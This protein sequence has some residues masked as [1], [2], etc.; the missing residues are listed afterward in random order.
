MSNPSPFEQM[1][2]EYINRA[3]MDPQGEFDR[4]IVNTNPVQAIEGNITSALNFFDVDLALYQQQLAGLSPAAP[5][6][7][8]SALNNAATAHS[9][10]M[11]AKDSQSHQLPGEAGLGSRISAAGYDH[12]GY[13]AENIFA[14]TQSPAYGHAGFFIDWGNTPTGIQNPAGHRNNIMNENLTEVGIGMVADSSDSTNVGP[15]VVTQDFGDRWDYDAQFVG[16]AY[17][18]TDLDNFYSIGEGAGGINVTLTSPVGGSIATATFSS[19]GFQ[20]EGAPGLNTLTFSGGGI[21]GSVSVD[22]L[23]GSDNVKVDLVNGTRIES[24]ADATLGDGVLDL[25]LLGQSSTE[26][27]GN[28]LGNTLVGSSGD[29][30]MWGKGGGDSLSGGQGN[31]ELFGNVGDDFIEGGAGDDLLHGGKDNDWV[32]GLEHADT[33]KGG[34][35]SDTLEGGADNDLLYGNFDNDSL[36]GESGADY[37]HGG[38]DDDWLDGGS[39]TDTL[40]GGQGEDTLNGGSGAD[41]LTGGGGNDVFDFRSISDSAAGHGNRDV[42]AGGFDSPG[43]GAGD[44]IDVSDIGL[45][46]FLG[47][48]A[49]SGTGWSEL[50]VAAAGTDDAI[51]QGDVDGNSVADFEIIIEDCL[52]NTFGAED[53]VGLF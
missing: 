52:A 27:V 33:L 47:E 17:N 38:K 41:R 12:W 39:G 24:S 48:G 1:M 3:R 21:S 46:V 5:L 13:L 11:I 28:A 44:L 40:I 49:F 15:Y 9:Q 30:R 6:A 7:W 50:R 20:I 25:T 53:F 18:D 2:L 32:D 34:L 45:F 43:A 51:V 35:G 23:F 10:L 42:I 8:N 31:D 19:G 37:L 14:Y 22:V 29:N 4:F 16:V 36:M 26:G